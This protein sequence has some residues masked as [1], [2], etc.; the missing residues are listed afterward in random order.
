MWWLLLFVCACHGAPIPDTFTLSVPDGPLSVWMGSSIILPC[1]LSPAFTKSLQVRWHRPDKY[2]TPVLLYENRQVQE[3]PADPQYR[4]R[5]SLI[6]QLEN[7]NV[8]LKLENVSLADSGEFVCFVVGDVWYEQASVHLIVKVMGSPPVLSVTYGGSGQANVTCV[9]DGWA[10]QPTLTWRNNGGTEIPSQSH[11]SATDAHGLVSVTSWL[12]HSSSGSKWVACSVG[13]PEEERKESRILPYISGAVTVE[14][15]R[16]LRDKEAEMERLKQKSEAQAKELEERLIASGAEVERLK[17]ESTGPWKEVFISFLVLLLLSSATVFVL[18]RKG[19][20]KCK[21]SKEAETESRKTLEPQQDKLQA[22]EGETES[23]L[24]EQS[25]E[26]KSLNQKITDLQ[27]Q[28][29]KSKEEVEP[30]NET[31]KDLRSQ[32]DKS[33]G[34]VE[35]LKQQITDLDNSKREVEIPNQQITDLRSQLDKS[36]GEVEALKQQI[37]DLDNSKREVEIPNQQ[38]TDLRSQLDK[39]KGEVEALKQQITDLDNSKREVEIPNQQI[40]DLRSQLDKSKG[41]VE[42]LKQQITDLDNSKREVEIPNQQITD[43]RSQLD[44]SK[45]EVE[46][47]KQQITDLD[48]SKREVEIPNQQITDLR[49]QLDKSKGEVE[50]LKQQITDLDNSKREVEIPNQQITD[51]RSQLDKSKGEVEALKQQITDLD[52]SKREVEIPNQQIT[53]LR[54]QLDKSKGE[55]EALKQQ[56]TDLDNSKREVEIPNQQITDLRSQLDKSKGEVEALKQ[57]ITDLDNSKREVEIPNQQ[58][59]D[60]DNS[61]REVEIPNQQIT[62]LRSE[63]NKSKGEV[64]AQKQQIT[65]LNNTKLEVET[66]KQ[67]ITERQSQLDESKGKVETL[68]QQVEGLLKKQREEVESLNQMIIVTWDRLKDIKES[69]TLDETSIQDN[70]RVVFG[71]KRVHCTKPYSKAN[72]N[73]PQYV[74][75]KD[76]FSSGQHYWEVRVANKESWFVGVCCATLRGRREKAF[77]RQN[78]CWLLCYD[79]D[80]G[81]YVNGDPITQ[82]QLIISLGV[83]LDCFRHSLTFYDVESQSVLYAF[84]DVRS[85]HPLVPVLSPGVRDKTS[86]IIR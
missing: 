52:N 20:I 59:T 80:Q 14:L 61:K 37:T 18:Y 4:G 3:Q 27:S 76:T 46:A 43:L 74:L 19:F 75:C 56:I 25:E 26:V 33:K 66:L 62:D 67:Q 8:S 72:S 24:K 13:L 58:I 70:L 82:R 55:V 50:A 21:D 40:T 53:D 78:D 64:E 77:T 45:G 54:S 57:Q 81:L 83:F 38:I 69:P 12:V 30:R 36:K 35:A 29:D 60:L 34:E 79:K 5:V 63:L 16:I 39:S 73:Q 51:L 86:L 41:E 47:L 84:H 85:A 22:S 7:R 65:E 32:L 2:K 1:S 28:L 71:G 42:A 15:E 17:Q 44:K 68:N 10:P 31:I 11:H 49:S 48:N 23:L 9:S 6:G